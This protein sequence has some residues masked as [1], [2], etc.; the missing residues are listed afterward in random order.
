MCFDLDK[1]KIVERREK[2]LN[3][4][5]AREALGSNRI[6]SRARGKCTWTE[7]DHIP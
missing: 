3:I 4:S 5:R 1:N 6:G 2:D 7:A